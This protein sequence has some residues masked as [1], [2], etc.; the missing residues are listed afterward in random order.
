M[1]LISVFPLT[2]SFT[3]RL[4]IGINPYTWKV[5]IWLAAS[6]SSGQ[7][8]ILLEGNDIEQLIMVKDIILNNFTNSSQQKI[9]LKTLELNF[10]QMYGSL[11]LRMTHKNS[12]LSI[13]LQ[14]RTTQMMFECLELVQIRSVYLH[15]LLPEIKKMLSKLREM[16]DGITE[17]NEEKLK[18]ELL[19]DVKFAMRE[20]LVFAPDE[21]K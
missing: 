19:F 14:E 21:I 1:L 7:L 9:I 17:S 10:C 2:I 16:K 4:L 13:N 8:T 6:I 11:C 15:D 18:P 3:K 5:E 12:R 20:L